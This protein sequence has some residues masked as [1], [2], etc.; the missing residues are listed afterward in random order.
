MT[1]ARGVTVGRGAGGD[2]RKHLVDV[3]VD[4]V[5]RLRGRGTATVRAGVNA[6]VETLAAWSCA[7]E[8]RSTGT[9]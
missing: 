1:L 8:P 5:L 4:H 6:D 3:E 9:R 7:R 2:A